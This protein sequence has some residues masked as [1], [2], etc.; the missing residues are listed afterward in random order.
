MGSGMYGMRSGARV[1]EG[2][3]ERFGVRERQ[4]LSVALE[5]C[6]VRLEVPETVKLLDAGGVCEK[7]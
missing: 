4:L 6:G 5:A 1:D 3:V 7:N 2:V